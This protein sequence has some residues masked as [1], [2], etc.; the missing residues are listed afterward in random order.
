MIGHNSDPVLVENQKESWLDCKTWNEL[1]SG[2]T[3]C[4]RLA[5]NQRVVNCTKQLQKE[6]Y[7]HKYKLGFTSEDR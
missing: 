6:L 1:S 2:W 7:A 3:T 5:S 4:L